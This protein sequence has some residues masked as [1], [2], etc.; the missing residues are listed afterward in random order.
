MERNLLG[1][2]FQLILPIIWLIQ[3]LKTPDSNTHHLMEH[4]DSLVCAG[5]ASCCH[6]LSCSVTSCPLDRGPNRNTVHLMILI[7][8]SML[9]GGSGFAVLG[10]GGDLVILRFSPR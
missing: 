9:I 5:V 8:L 10:R 3:Y 4:G 7:A 6:F 1:M 2:L